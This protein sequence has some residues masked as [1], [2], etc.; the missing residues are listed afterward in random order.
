MNLMDFCEYQLVGVDYDDSELC[1]LSQLA[2][3]SLFSILDA[4]DQMR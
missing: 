3:R 2:G 4:S 1:V